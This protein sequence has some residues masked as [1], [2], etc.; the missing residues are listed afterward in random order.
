MTSIRT[1]VRRQD[2]AQVAGSGRNPERATLRVQMDSAAGPRTKAE[3]EGLME[4]VCERGNLWSAYERVVGNKGAAG[5]DGIDRLTFK[6]HLQQHWPTIKAKLLAGTYIPQAVRRVDIA[7]PQGGVRTLGIPTLTDRLIQQALHQVL[8]PIFEAQ[9]SA[10]SYGFR[11]G[12]SAHQAVLAAKQYVAEGRRVVVDMDLE[13]FFDRVNHDILME[14]VSRGVDDR[15]VLKLIRRYLEAGMMADGVVSPRTQGTPQGGPLSPLLS[16]ILL[17]ELDRELESRGHAFCRY[18]DDCNIYVR[19]QAAGDRVLASITQF[20]EERL[21][22][23]VNE[24]KS[25]VAKPWERKFLGYSLT[26]HKSPKLRIAPTGVERLKAKVGEVFRRGRGR[27][28]R[29]TIEDLNPVLRGWAAYFKLTESRR[30]LEDLD[31]W[32]RRKLRCLLWRQWKRPYRRAQNLMRAGL[33]EERAFRSAFNQRGPWWN[34]GASHMNAAYRQS[35]FDRLGLV[36][37][38]ATTQRLQRLA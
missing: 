30:V 19:S 7:K 11:L 17:T 36:S 32:I 18:A 22:L 5:V 3:T 38:L 28:V 16:N 15:R 23:Q 8:S 35:Y 37:L 9:F 20:L 10:S 2:G 24:A 6:A 12:R 27:S 4:A 34:S 1:E 26:A 14:K 21:K 25:A 13:K 29:R 33:P 31:G